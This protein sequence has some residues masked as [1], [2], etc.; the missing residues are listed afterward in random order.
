MQPVW[1]PYEDI[2]Y[3]AELAPREY[4]DMVSLPNCFAIAALKQGKTKDIPIALLIFTMHPGDKSIIHWL[5]VAP[6]Y[7][8]HDI[9]SKLLEKICEMHENTGKK[10]LS[11]LIEGAGGKNRIWENSADFF[12]DRG[13]HVKKTIPGKWSI[14]VNEMLQQKF[15]LKSVKRKKEPG[16][17]VPL[18]ALDEKQRKKLLKKYSKD[19]PESIP[20]HFA[21]YDPDYS[22]VIFGK[23]GFDAVF[24]I[25]RAGRSFYPVV[26]KAKSVAMEE[27][28]VAFSFLAVADKEDPKEEM[29]VVAYKQSTAD[30]VGWYFPK[31]K[32]QSMVLLR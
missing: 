8:N 19:L 6:D 18:R 11:V 21:S 30:K 26:L 3:F 27:K 7:R 31:S 5:Y 1:V 12:L 32:A 13:F 10:K 25:R 17:I 4:L 22:C 28:L 16:A 24:L 15:F 29:I 14:S 2:E 20:P 23:K 9:G